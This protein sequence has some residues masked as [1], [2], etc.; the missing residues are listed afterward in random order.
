MGVALVLFVPPIRIQT[1][2]AFVLFVLGGCGNSASTSKGSSSAPAALTLAPVTWNPA[3]VDVGTAQAVVE[4]DKSLLVLG[5]KGVITLASGSVVSTDATI[6]AWKSAAS[7]PSPDGQSTWVVGV[8]GTGLLERVSSDG[9]R[10]LPVNDKYGLTMDKVQDIA[11]GA[12]SAG[13]MLA[14]GIAVTDGANLTRYD[15]VAHA[16]AAHGSAIALA[17]GAAIRVFDKGKETDVSLPDAQ[18]CAYD[19]AGD[20]LA[21]TTHRLYEVSDGAAV[22]LFDAGDR[23]IHQLAGAGTSVWFSV[24]GDLGVVRAG[25]VALASGGTLPADARIIGSA[26]GDIWTLAG[27]H[28]SRMSAGGPAVG[29]AGG[30]EASWNAN[31]QPIYAAVCSTCHSPPGSGKDSSNIDLSTYGAWSMRRDHVYT[32][33]VT[34]AGTATSMPP[35]NTAVSL[36]DAQRAAIAAWAKP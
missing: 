19:Q 14:T 17:D 9:S 29:G 15:G 18:L 3:N 28:L 31:V 4:V 32:R 5:S 35:P 11:G 27:G 8:D 23:T 24:D 7:L 6:T 36:T 16:I 25:A 33:V 2:L 30:D 12:P 26:S 13:F 21:A 10:A 1:S 22:L 20:L 34:Q